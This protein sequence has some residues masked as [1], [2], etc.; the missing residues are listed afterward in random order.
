MVCAPS[1]VD[2]NIGDTGKRASN[3]RNRTGPPRSQGH[4]SIEVLHA[5]EVNK[6][7]L[8]SLGD[9]TVS[10]QSNQVITITA[11]GQSMQ[12]AINSYKRSLSSAKSF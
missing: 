12:C 8:T 1:R 11:A 9:D 6:R 3:A 2:K 4:V 7:C 5:Q 10:L